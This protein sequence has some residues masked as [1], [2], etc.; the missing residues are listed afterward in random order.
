MSVQ[1]RPGRHQVGGEVGDVLTQRR[2]IRLILIDDPQQLVLEVLIHAL[3]FLVSLQQ[4]EKKT[5]ELF[6]QR[7]Q[8]SAISGKDKKF[9]TIGCLE[10]ALDW[11]NG[12]RSAVKRAVRR[13]QPKPSE[14]R[15]QPGSETI[16]DNAISRGAE[17]WR[18]DER[19]AEGSGGERR[20]G[21]EGGRE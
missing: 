19:R 15:R 3:Q 13:V 11:P 7:W 9:A 10:E 16:G 18:I 2:L 8:A 20:G 5:T 6:G 1:L 17:E 4:T 21:R 12:G 14:T